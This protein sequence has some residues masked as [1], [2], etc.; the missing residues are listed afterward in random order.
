MSSHL[1]YVYKTISVLILSGSP[2]GTVFFSNNH[3]PVD[4]HSST[5]C[6]GLFKKRKQYGTEF[7]NLFVG[8]GEELLFQRIPSVSPF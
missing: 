2:V 5:L 8:T 6:V 1:I 7:H 4:C 3:C